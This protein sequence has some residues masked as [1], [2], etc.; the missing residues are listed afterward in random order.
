MFQR[1]EIGLKNKKK[2]N[3][4]HNTNYDNVNCTVVTPNMCHQRSFYYQILVCD[5]FNP[6]TPC[7]DL[8]V[9]CPDHRCHRCPSA[10][11]VLSHAHKS[12]GGGDAGGPFVDAVVIVKNSRRK[13]RLWGLAAPNGVGQVRAEAQGQPLEHQVELSPEAPIYPEV[14]DAVEEAIGGGQPHHHELHPLRNA[15]PWHSWHT[16]HMRVEAKL[17]PTAHRTFLTFCF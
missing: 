16:Q 10:V 14:E 2:Y 5:L 8:S 12:A 15:A 7:S 6:S 3:N 9:T 13:L 4:L 11:D 17:I 1:T